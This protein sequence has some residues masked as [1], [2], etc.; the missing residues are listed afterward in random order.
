MFGIAGWGVP[1]AE[2]YLETGLGIFDPANYFPDLS[3][4]GPLNWPNWGAEGRVN[5]KSRGRD[6]SFEIGTKNGSY[7]GK[8]YQ[9][10][11]NGCFF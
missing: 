3:T 1:F 4:Y 8:N 2:E 9:A 6:L 10:E 7:L 11:E 5:G